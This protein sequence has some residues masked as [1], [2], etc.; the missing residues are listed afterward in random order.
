MSQLLPLIWSLHS[1]HNA[2]SSGAMTDRSVSVNAE[3]FRHA[4]LDISKPTIRVLE[5]LPGHKKSLVRCKLWH[6][7][8]GES[9]SCLSYTWGPDT[10]QRCILINGKK[11]FVRQNLHDFLLQARK[12]KIV[13]PLWVD[14]IC[15]DQGNVAERNHQVQQMAELYSKAQQVFVYPGRVVTRVVNLIKFTTY[16]LPQYMDTINREIV[17]IPCDLFSVCPRSWVRAFADFLDCDYWWRVWVLQEMFLARSLTLV[18][19]NLLL[20]MKDLED[21]RNYAAFGSLPRSFISDSDG[22]SNIYY[23]LAKG[24][25]S[26]ERRLSDDHHSLRDLNYGLNLEKY[27]CSDRRDRIYGL[28]GIVPELRRIHVRY[29]ENEST[30][31][32]RA[33]TELPNETVN[34]LLLNLENLGYGFLFFPWLFCLQCFYQL[35][36]T[37][38]HTF[39][40]SDDPIF[41]NT[42][43]R[44]LIVLDGTRRSP[45]YAS[46]YALSDHPSSDYFR[47]KGICCSDRWGEKR[48]LAQSQY[49][50][51]LC[52]EIET[53]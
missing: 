26:R 21:I 53:A 50:R 13:A 5:I 12:L 14:A 27:R 3:L 19:N 49:G 40:P 6:T 4:P 10:D 38:Q 37:D 33:A 41:E 31:L 44:I 42:A 51:S 1:D 45:E 18:L 47:M 34:D 35:S 32:F 48:F 16:K 9:H 36:K 15:I 7:D 30:M 8:L 46:E 43:V 22:F 17:R 25:R 24:A 29:D 20:D 2:L 52:L 39:W 23:L 11:H 28:M